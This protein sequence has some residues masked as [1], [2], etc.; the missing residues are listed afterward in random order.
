VETQSDY[1]RVA[2]VL[3]MVTREGRRP[4]ADRGGVFIRPYRYSQVV[5]MRG[6]MAWCDIRVR[7]D[8]VT[9]S[10]LMLFHLGAPLLSL[11]KSALRF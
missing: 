4:A 6:A 9:P 11:D 8:V 10:T 3:W 1:F 7:T 5:E 2:G